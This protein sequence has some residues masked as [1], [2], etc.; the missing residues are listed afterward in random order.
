[1]SY[2]T[3]MVDV[4][5][6]QKEK[7]LKAIRS[8]SSAQLRLSKKNLEGGAYPIVIT[9][10][11]K[12]R[13]KRNKLQGKGMVLTLNPKQLKESYNV[14]EMMGS[15]WFKD[16]AN[17][18]GSVAK[19]VAENTLGKIVGPKLSEDIVGAVGKLATKG[20]DAIDSAITK[21]KKKGK[22]FGMYPFGSGMDSDEYVQCPCTQCLCDG[23]GFISDNT[24]KVL[25][26]QKQKR[27]SLMQKKSLGGGRIRPGLSGP[28]SL[29]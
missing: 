1:M 4:S 3:I 2:K 29:F 24:A 26:M 13:V 16:I 14:S 11:Q 5:P 19:P 6:A 22:G 7:V 27:K 9:K 25:K 21:D 23:S 15:G 8:G 17:F 20:V 18:I 10:T 12:N 28:Q